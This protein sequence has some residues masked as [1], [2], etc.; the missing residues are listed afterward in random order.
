MVME[1]VRGVNLEQ[2]L[3]RHRA[4]G[5]TPAGGSGRFRRLAR[6]PRALTYAHH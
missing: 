2:F 6:G 3:D 4:L 1:F 5:R